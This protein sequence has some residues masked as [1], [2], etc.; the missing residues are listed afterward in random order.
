MKRIRC[1]G[2]GEE[3]LVGKI[4]C[5]GKNYAAHAKEME[6]EVPE[7]PVVFLKPSTAII[8]DGDEIKIPRMSHEVHHEVE[9]VVA[10]GKE[11]KN[12]R[13]SDSA[14]YVLGYAIGLDMTMRDVQN[15]AKKQGHP[16]TVAK[17]FDTSAPVSDIIP[18][19]KIN[20]PRDLTISCKVNGVIRQKSSTRNMIFSIDTII[21]YISSI[22]TLERGD[23]IFTGTPEG[24]SRIVAGDT[25]EAELVG[26]TTIS[27]RV[28]Q[29]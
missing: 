24:V 22:F 12:I 15:E 4:F 20:N 17:G 26:Y 3:I 18:A 13:A 14:G 8:R 1:N 28:V 16:W 21:E 7:E 23:L 10:I 6:S 9:L 5:L 19:A 11:G 29:A 25:I 2:S 27:H